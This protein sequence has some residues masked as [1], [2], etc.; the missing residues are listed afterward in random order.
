MSA[1]TAVV[2]VT[3]SLVMIL[4][5]P[6]GAQARSVGGAVADIPSGHAR[7]PRAT[8]ASGEQMLYSGGPVLHSNRTHLIFWQ[9]QGSGLTFEPGYE[10]LIAGFLAN[11]AQD[12][13]KP[14]SI[15]GLSGQYTDAS[16]P[17]AYDST[18]GGAVQATDPLPPNG[19]TEPSGTGPGWTVCLTANQLAAEVEHVVSTDHLPVTGA[20]VYFLVT[21][22]GLGDC[23][24]SSSTS[25]ALG[26]SQGGY[27]A[28]HDQSPAGLVL[29]ANIPYNAVAGHCTS[30]NPRPN[31][32][33]ADPAINSISHEHFE[34]LTDPYFD[35]W[36]D[37]SGAEAGDV[38]VL[39]YGANLGGTGSTAWNEAIAGGHY[40]L[41]GEWSND[42]SACM[43][44][45]E[46]DPI[47]VVSASS[48]SPGSRVRFAGR[49]SDP[50]GAI[51]AYNWFFGDGTSAHQRVIYHPFRRAGV[52]RVV[53]RTTDSAGNRAFYAR[54]IRVSAARRGR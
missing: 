27:C 37:A 48:A 31:A 16:G 41:Q 52:Y 26:G 7:L 24:D 13:R 1:R 33:S 19:C 49:A 11:V 25:C 54:T 10:A 15:Y 40:Y 38:C 43:P 47:M 28:Y 29:W 17:A 8:R 9:P 44:R 4:A 22:N 53:L 20:D 12:S 51:V 23:L 6:A 36:Y 45:D 18:Y 46:S 3:A 14:T 42:D 5:L 30:D 39:S 21:P 2:A 34:M 32:S 35:A 50:D